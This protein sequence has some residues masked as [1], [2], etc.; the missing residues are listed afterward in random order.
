MRSIGETPSFVKGHSLGNTAPGAGGEPPPKQRGPA[1][2]SHRL[3]RR[4]DT[5][6]AWSNMAASHR[7]A[8]GIALATTSKKIPR[9]NT[10]PDTAKPGT[11]PAGEN[12]QH[13]LRTPGSARQKAPSS[14][15][16]PLLTPIERKEVERS[17]IPRVVTIAVTMTTPGKHTP[18]STLYTPPHR[19]LGSPQPP[20]R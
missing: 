20:R 15:P 8:Q 3:R 17:L 10:E 13:G 12:H 6:R 1:F 9:N 7:S 16:T 14:S 5:S 19:D 18:K 2:C 4:R 11:A